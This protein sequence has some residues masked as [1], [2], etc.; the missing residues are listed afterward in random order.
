SDTGL[1]GRFFRQEP[2]GLTFVAQ[3]PVAMTDHTHPQAQPLRALDDAGPGRY[4]LQLLLPTGDVITRPFE[5]RAG[6]ATT[7]DVVLPEG[8]HEW[9]TLQTLAGRFT[10]PLAQTAGGPALE[11]RAASYFQLK[12]RP[13]TGFELRFMAMEATAP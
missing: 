12:Q 13:R 2:D 7:L 9:T 11:A 1:V 3:A 5:I 4:L 10:A 8:P 6:E